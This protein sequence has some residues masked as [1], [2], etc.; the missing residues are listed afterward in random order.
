L[1]SLS[2]F[3]LED[4]HFDT[5]ANFTSLASFNAL[6]KSGTIPQVSRTMTD[7]PFIELLPAYSPEHITAIGQYCFRF[8][9]NNAMETDWVPCICIE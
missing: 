6:T 7:F 8:E 9:R 3:V 5:H 2:T 1:C 4:C